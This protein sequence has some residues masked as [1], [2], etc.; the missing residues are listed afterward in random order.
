MHHY[1][2]HILYRVYHTHY[3][4]GKAF[5]ECYTRQI[6]LDKYFIDKWF[7]AEYI[8]SG[9]RQRFSRVS[10]NTWQK[11]AIGKLTITKKTQKSAKHF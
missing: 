7:F 2:T 5:N 8:F 6:I 9:T 1:R 3:T 11:K 10:K 4:L